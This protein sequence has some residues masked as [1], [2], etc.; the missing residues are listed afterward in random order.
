MSKM[1]KEWQEALTVHGF[2]P[3]PIDGI[4]GGRTKAAIDRCIDWQRW[5]GRNG[6]NAGPVDG[7][8]GAQ[9]D[10]AVREFQR[11]AGIVVDAII[12]FQTVNARNKWPSRGQRIVRKIIDVV[13][14]PVINKIYGS[15][16]WPD[17]ALHHSVSHDGDARTIDRWFK[18]RG[19]KKGGYHEVIRR[20]GIT[21][22]GAACP[23]LLR[24]IDEAGAHIQGRNYRTYGICF[25]SYDGELTSEQVSAGKSRI[26][27]LNAHGIGTRRVNGHRFFS[28]QNTN[29]PG[30]LPIE[31]L[32]ADNLV[33]RSFREDLA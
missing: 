19:F 7:W 9:T 16:K 32:I 31:I 5:L 20:D 28:G 30:D 18:A 4:K 1:I 15:R 29:C 23:K 33:I 22:T 27:E 25:I 12:G 17:I 21:Q 6:F 13:V 24:T 3:G 26:K 11:A 8:P 2:N 10:K 14:N